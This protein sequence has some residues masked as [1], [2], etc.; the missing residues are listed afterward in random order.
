[1]RTTQ[2]EG[3][4]MKFAHI[5]RNACRFSIAFMCRLLG[6]SASG[7]HA[8]STRKPSAR[9]QENKR[10]RVEIRSRFVRSRRTYGAPRMHRALVAAGR[11]T[12][13]N[14]VARL[15]RAEGLVARPK[16]RFKKTTRRGDGLCAPNVIQQDFDA[17]A[18]NEKW[19]ATSRTSA[20]GK[21]GS[22]LQWSSTSFLGA[23][24]ALLS[25]TTCAPS[26][27]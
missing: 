9:S 20:P 5:Q 3:K 10:L 21:A 8:W 13:K 16:K 6:V 23:L 26:C 25:T 7:F 27:L 11:S 24:S 18:P 14:R 1:M 19:V 12:G 17:E 22:T 4:A 2:R 15:M